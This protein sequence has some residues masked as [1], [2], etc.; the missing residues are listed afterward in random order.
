MQAIMERDKLK[1]QLVSQ[2]STWL[3]GQPIFVMPTHPVL[4]P[5]HSHWHLHLDLKNRSIGMRPWSDEGHPVTVE[6]CGTCGL[7]F[8][9]WCYTSGM[10]SEDW[11][12]LQIFPLS[13]IIL[14]IDQLCSSSFEVVDSYYAVLTRTVGPPERSSPFSLGIGSMMD[15]WGLRINCVGFFG[16][17]RDCMGLR[18]LGM[19]LIL[20]C[21]K[22]ALNLFHFWK[23]MHGFLAFWGAC[24]L[25]ACGRI[26]ESR[27]RGSH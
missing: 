3:Y 6:G 7:S 14:A 19:F 10:Q 15:W 24:W 17:G 5:Q 23:G 21:L 1:R 22:R 4:D 12:D 2:W 26:N 13:C 27:R 8:R 20:Q 16:L 11:R 25:C 9:T 18:S